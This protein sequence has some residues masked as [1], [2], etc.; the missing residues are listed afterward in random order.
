MTRQIVDGVAG[1]QTMMGRRPAEANVLM[2]VEEQRV[3]FDF[4]NGRISHRDFHVSMGDLVV[5]SA[6]SVGL[7]ETLDLQVSVP[8][9]DKW[10]QGKPLLAGLKGE[11]IPFP[12]GGT[13]W[14]S[15]ASGSASRAPAGCSSN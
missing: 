13:P 11:V 3:P 8:I 14:V 2:Q 15:S 6:G 10:I 9:P 4:K 7:D 12:M 5:S 1:L